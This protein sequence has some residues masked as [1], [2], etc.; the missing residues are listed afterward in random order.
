[1]D[2]GRECPFVF[3]VDVA[4]V[5]VAIVSCFFSFFFFSSFIFRLL[6]A[7]LETQESL[8]SKW[9]IYMKGKINDNNLIERKKLRQFF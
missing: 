3:F 6:I 8:L 7:A 9:S 1:M 5:D 4:V 2:G